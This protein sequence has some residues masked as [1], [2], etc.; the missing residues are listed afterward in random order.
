MVTN[1]NL[2]SRD[3]LLKK[4]MHA[5]ALL[6]QSE[7]HHMALNIKIIWPVAFAATL[8]STS[9]GTPFRIITALTSKTSNTSLFNYYLMKH[10]TYKNIFFLC[11][12]PLPLK[13][14]LQANILSWNFHNKCIL[15]RIYVWIDWDRLEQFICEVVRLMVDAPW[16]IFAFKEYKSCCECKASKQLSNVT[17]KLVDKA[18]TVVPIRPQL[19]RILNDI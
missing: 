19:Q 3:K 9:D 17:M 13:L 11:R 4:Y 10:S 5:N 7:V 16:T 18:G 6:Q 8:Y 15:F 1:S 14:Q 12:H 2:V